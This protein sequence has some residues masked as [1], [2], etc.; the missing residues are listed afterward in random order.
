VIAFFPAFLI[1]RRVGSDDLSDTTDSPEL[2]DED[3]T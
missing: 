2:V 3:P 1:R